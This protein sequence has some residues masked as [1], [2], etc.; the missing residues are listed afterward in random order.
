VRNGA[1][2]SQ[3][4]NLMRSVGDDM[5]GWEWRGGWKL[6]KKDKGGDMRPWEGGIHVGNMKKKG[7]WKDREKDKRGSRASPE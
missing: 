7:G 3:L 4:E 6:D 5:D 1:P 2:V